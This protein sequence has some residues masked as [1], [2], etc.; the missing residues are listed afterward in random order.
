MVAK[1]VGI[2]TAKERILA[3]RLLEKQ[4]QYPAYTAGMGIRVTLIPKDPQ[5]TEE[6]NV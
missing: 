3:I 5:K 2:L 4:V 6:R 1:E